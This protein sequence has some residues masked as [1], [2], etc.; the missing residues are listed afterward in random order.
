M[1]GVSLSSKIQQALEE[2]RQNHLTSTLY[3]HDFWIA[4]QKT[5]LQYNQELEVLN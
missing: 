5:S 1:L 2:Q 3:I 4:C